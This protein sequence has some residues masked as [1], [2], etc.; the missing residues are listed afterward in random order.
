MPD[1]Y[2][3]YVFRCG[4][5]TQPNNA[6]FVAKIRA[7]NRNQLFVSIDVVRDYKLE[8]PPS[9]TIRNTVDKE[10]ETKVNNWSNGRIWLVG[11]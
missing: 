5:A 4:R 9:M 8:L 3:A 2:G 1:L 6:Y 11:G 7:K 10:F